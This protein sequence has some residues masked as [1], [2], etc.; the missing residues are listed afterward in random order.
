MDS[1]FEKSVVFN[2]SE[3]GSGKAVR[4][5]QDKVQDKEKAI[6]YLLECQKPKAEKKSHTNSQEDKTIFLH[7]FGNK[8]KYRNAYDTKPRKPPA[9]GFV[10]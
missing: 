4:T 5:R 8:R 9:G 1:A 10:S 3:T 7:Y 2:D 6:T